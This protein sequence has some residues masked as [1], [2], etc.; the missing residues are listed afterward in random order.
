MKQLY[1]DSILFTSEGLRHL[2]AN[3][4]ASQVVIGTDFPYIWNTTPVDH[5]MNTPGLSTAERRAILGETAAKLL[6]IAS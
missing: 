6:G 4:G 1:Y 2:I 3:A 5:I